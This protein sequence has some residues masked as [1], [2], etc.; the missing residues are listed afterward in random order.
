MQG[1][2]LLAFPE[3]GGFPMSLTILGPLGRK[4]SFL[5]DQEFD[6]WLQ[7]F[8]LIAPHFVAAQVQVHFDHQ[9][10][11]TSKD[12]IINHWRHKFIL[13]AKQLDPWRQKF[14]RESL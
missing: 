10:F 14:L 4:T 5:I 7:K 1:I 3:R 9:Q 11:D 12:S 2:P 8:I 6:H 13:I